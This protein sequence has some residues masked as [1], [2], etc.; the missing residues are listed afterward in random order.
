MNT[1]AVLLAVK[2][3]EK[4]IQQSI[5][6][7]LEQTYQD[8]ILFICP[9]NCSD[10]TISIIGKILATHDNRDKIYL[11]SKPESG[12]CDALNYLLKLVPKEI[13]YIAIQDA[14]DIWHPTKLEEQAKY[15][16]HFDIIGTKCK[17]I[18]DFGETLPLNNPIPSVNDEI[19]YWLK[20]KKQNP[21]INC[22]VLINKKFITSINGWDKDF[23]GVEDFF[24][25][26]QLAIWSMAKFINIDMELVSHRLHPNSHFNNSSQVT[27]LEAISD[28]VDENTNQKQIVE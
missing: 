15:M 13:K 14:D 10:N 24:M 1:I 12:K 18:N 9:N 19:R 27:K 8:F 3:G 17:Y 11:T 20:V 25:W 26:T 28:Y 4:H 16:N 5:L 2:N 7:V 21:I 23:E 22:S 6:S